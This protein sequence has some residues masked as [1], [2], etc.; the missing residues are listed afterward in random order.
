MQRQAN[1][2]TLAHCVLLELDGRVQRQGT[3][4]ALFY[5]VDGSH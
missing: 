3:E 4:P 2:E 1:G 5:L